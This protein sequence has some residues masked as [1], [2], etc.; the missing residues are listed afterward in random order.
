[1][2]MVTGS[3]LANGGDGAQHQAQ[4]NANGGGGAGGGILIHAGDVV[5]SS[6]AVLS[7]V[8]GDGGGY[9]PV[10]GDP[11]FS[12][13]I[14]AG[15][16]GGGGRILI[17]D[18]DGNA[19]ESVGN[20]NVSGG[21][22]GFAP[23]S[24]GMSGV[25]EFR[26]LAPA[27][28]EKQYEFDIE[29][30]D[31]ATETITVT[32]TGGG[33]F[34]VSH[35]YGD[36]GV[37]SFIVSTSDTAT[38]VSAEG[39]IAVENVAPQL[40]VA[41]SS[42]IVNEGTAAVNSVL[43]TDVPADTIAVSASIG[44]VLADGNGGWTWSLDETDGPLSTTV[45]ITAQDDD[46]GIST[47]TF[48]LEVVNLAPTADAGGPYLTFD[49]MPITLTGSGSDVAGAADPLSYT[50]DLD[51]DNIFGETGLDAANGN[52]VGATPVLNP[53][54]LSGV[55]TVK[56][57]VDDGDGG[58]TE[59][60]AHVT[61]LNKGSLL[62]DGV[63]HVVG[64]DGASDLVLI[65][66]CGSDIYVYATFN[67]SNPAIFAA[68]DVDL[69]HVRTRGGHDVVVTTSNV[70]ET[71]IIDGGSEND[72][73]RGGSG[74]NT[75]FGRTGRDTLYG[76]S[77]DDRLFGGDGDDDLVGAGG[78]DVLVGGTG[79]DILD[80]GDGR[81]LLIGG[82]NED[83]LHGGSQDDILIGGYTI[84]DDD[85]AALDSIMAVWNSELSFNDRVSALTTG[86]GW[87]V[88][89]TTVFDD[90]AADHIIGAAG[91]DLAFGDTSKYG[92]GV[93]DVLSLSSAQ[94]TLI[95]LN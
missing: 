81:D 90:D 13:G 1:M 23:A 63:L 2:L 26:E 42:V 85:V 40:S 33:S 18:D 68:A 80:G 62:I 31:G 43:A 19:A 21:R 95:A 30:G 93:K 34:S 28:T 64:N 45:T 14:P 54:G 27:A 49:D 5:L 94:D 37:Y 52:E 15:G 88:A 84:H 57:R 17:A 89:G 38:P 58:V 82:S 77:A 7:A 50:W 48:D 6:G 47:V 32:A 66:Q 39:E 91:R 12:T 3:V 29:W 22:T 79:N 69:I 78:S 35:V 53:D 4:A 11:D 67:D 25:I 59:D 76:G 75:I 10:P 44:V 87:L 72:L 73:L 20:G 65:T 8:G 60:T 61:V 86:T 36:D 92:D 83:R 74:E 56:L 9:S 71:M 41:A 51:G 24:P 55:V 46:G 70:H 16:G